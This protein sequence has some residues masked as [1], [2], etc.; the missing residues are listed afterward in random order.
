MARLFILHPYFY[1]DVCV[2]HKQLI[3]TQLVISKRS[4]RS[5]A[6]DQQSV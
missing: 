6:M 5:Y 4:E 1:T 3:P 2:P